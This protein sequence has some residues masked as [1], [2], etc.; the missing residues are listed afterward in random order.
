MIA[1]D[2]GHAIICKAEKE[3]S[4]IQVLPIL[5]HLAN[6]FVINTV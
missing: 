5:V 2:L 4:F 6:Y 3:R 1:K